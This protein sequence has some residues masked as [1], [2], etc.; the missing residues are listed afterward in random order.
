MNKLFNIFVAT[1]FCVST[2]FSMGG[3]TE[4]KKCDPLGV[5]TGSVVS[6]SISGFSE[7][8]F[9]SFSVVRIGSLKSD[10]GTLLS[11]FENCVK[12]LQKS[13]NDEKF[14][15]TLKKTEKLIS[16]MLE[17]LD[18]DIKKLEDSDFVENLFILLCFCKP[19]KFFQQDKKCTN[20]NVVKNI[21]YLMNLLNYC[22]VCY[23]EYEIGSFIEIFEYLQLI[24]KLESLCDLRK[25]HDKN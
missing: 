14:R 24:P 18:T 9:Q 21:D 15:K 4:T 7:A 3:H 22:C 2:L 20:L 6:L 10:D 13:V 12:D 8:N 23:G 16:P 11:F 1:L 25:F 19:S 17:S 5:L